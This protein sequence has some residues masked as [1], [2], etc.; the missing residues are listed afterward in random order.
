MTW[1]DDS[2][3]QC[4]NWHNLFFLNGGSKKIVGQ[5][6]NLEQLLW[7]EK[8][9]RLFADNAPKLEK[10]NQ[11]WFHSAAKPPVHRKVESE[12]SSPLAKTEMVR[13][14]DLSKY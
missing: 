3:N 12:S 13:G 6:F 4:H 9:F 5:L 11:W 7:T 8:S 10:K 2:D 1:R 14:S